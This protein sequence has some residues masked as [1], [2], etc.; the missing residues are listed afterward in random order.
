MLLFS[1]NGYATGR[2]GPSAN[3]C[4]ADIRVSENAAGQL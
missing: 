4:A 3:V 2:T 1:I